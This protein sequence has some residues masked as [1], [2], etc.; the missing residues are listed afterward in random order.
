MPTV[1]KLVM[2]FGALLIAMCVA[3]VVHGATKD[4]PLAVAVFGFFC[5]WLGFSFAVAM[6][7]SSWFIGSAPKR[8][9][10]GQKLADKVSRQHA[11]KRQGI[12]KCLVGPC[13]NSNASDSLYCPVHK[14]NPLDMRGA[15]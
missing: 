7:V 5:L 1:V 12:S 2:R 10:I 6:L 4:T 8:T 3:L 13:R 11:G 14:G 15:Q 9:A